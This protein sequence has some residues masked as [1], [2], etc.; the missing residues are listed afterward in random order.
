MFISTAALLAWWASQV[1]WLPF[2]RRMYFVDFLWC[3]WL[4]GRFSSLTSDCYVLFSSFSSY[5]SR[6]LCLQSNQELLMLCFVL[7]DAPYLIKK[8][9]FFLNSTKFWGNRVK[10]SGMCSNLIR[11]MKQ[12]LEIKTLELILNCLSA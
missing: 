5:E 1:S 6:I 4:S 8:P 2:S 9:S 7:D 11:Y 3:L 10:V 12:L